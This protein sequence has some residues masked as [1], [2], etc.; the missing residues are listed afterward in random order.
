VL[1]NQVHAPRRRGNPLGGSAKLL[2]IESLDSG[3][4]LGKRSFAF[5]SARCH[6]LA[7]HRISVVEPVQEVYRLSRAI[8][9]AQKPNDN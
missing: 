6:A 2:L 9:K 7:L 1:A 4:L 5:I 8:L 3:H